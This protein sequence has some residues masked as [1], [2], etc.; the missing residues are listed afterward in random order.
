VADDII[1]R[2]VRLGEDIECGGDDTCTICVAMQEIRQLRDQRDDHVGLE[3]TVRVYLAALDETR[4]PCAGSEAADLA[5]DLHKA[6]K[7]MRGAVTDPGAP[8]LAQVVDDLEKR[9]G[10]IEKFTLSMAMQR[11]VKR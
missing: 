9:V 3:E 7:M 11:A 4:R 8:K 5:L 2:L 10:R 1:A 6:E